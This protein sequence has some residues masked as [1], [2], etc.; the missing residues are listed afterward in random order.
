M[1]LTR[2]SMLGTLATGLSGS[3]VLLGRVAIGDESKESRIFVDANNPGGN[4][5]AVI[6]VDPKTGAWSKILQR[7]ETSPRVS[8]DGRFIADARQEQRRGDDWILRVVNLRE[9]RITAE[10]KIELP[11]RICWSSDSKQIIV[12][13]TKRPPAKRE[14]A[15]WR[16]DAT[17]P[18]RTRLPL[19]ATECVLDWSLD[20]RWLLTQSLR[21]PDKDEQ[22]P[23]VPLVVSYHVVHPDGSGDRALA[24][25][26]SIPGP[27]GRRQFV[28]EISFSPDGRRLC[29]NVGPSGGPLDLGVADLDGKDQRRVVLSDRDK[30][31]GRAVWSPD[32]KELAF[33][34]NRATRPIISEDLLISSDD[35][36]RVRPLHIKFP[37]PRWSILNWRRKP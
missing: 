23:G 16:F 17:S 11:L 31:V 15:T 34:M 21:R 25:L 37:E 18:K 5:S 7:S 19:P 9:E 33:V 29:Y 14:Y 24:H 1:G 3:S 35:G 2:R 6:S 20:G 28:S 27:E 32:G 8:P 30:S 4:S 13:T 26:D 36:K 10:H 22:K 12:S